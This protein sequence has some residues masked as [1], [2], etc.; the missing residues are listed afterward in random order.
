VGAEALV[1]WQHPTRGLIAPDDF[2]PLAEETGLIVPLGQWVLNEA[3]GWA[4]RWA[5]LQEATD[6]PF[7]V[8]VNVSALQVATDGFADGVLAAL[9][10]A[11]LNPSS[12]ALELTETF[13]MQDPRAAFSVLGRL[14]DCGVH[15]WV[16][17]FGTGYSS[18]AY[19]KRLPI[20]LLKVD[21]SFVRGLGP[22]PEDWAIVA[23]VVS[24]AR[25]VGLRVIAEGVETESQLSRLRELGCDEAQGFLMS[26]PKPPD[27]FEDLLLSGPQW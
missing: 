11:G 24:L 20:D 13:M 3:C 4:A 26:R 18:L 17:D 9:A 14:R 5:A 25:T 23:A 1:R 8:S 16:D 10:A 21:R 15:I 12:L 27:A 19:L 2:T 22:D 6:R 7:I